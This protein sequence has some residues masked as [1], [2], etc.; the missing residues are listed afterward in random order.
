M[1]SL[2]ATTKKVA[3]SFSR[4]QA[5]SYKQ[6]EI[7]LQKKLASL[8]KKKI[9]FPE[10]VPELQP[11]VNVVERQLADIQQYHVE[12]LALRSGIRWR[13]LGELSAGYLKRTIAT[14][15]SRQMI[16]SLIHPVT[17]VLCSSRVDM[18][19]AASTFYSDLYFPDP[20]DPDAI[21]SILSTLPSSL[22]LASTDQNALT[23]PIVF[24]DILEGVS[25]CPS[26]SSPGTDGLPYEL[27][28]LIIT[29]PACRDITLAVYNDAL[30][31]GIFP[32]SWLETSVSL[33]PKKGSLSDLKNWRPISLI[34]TDA[35]VFTRILSARLISC[36]DDLITP[37]QSG[38][39]RH[40]FIADNGL[41]MK[42]VMDF[43]KSTNSKAL[44][45][46]LDQE[47]AYDRVHPDYLQQVLT[48][49]GFPPSFVQSVLGLFF[50][51]QLRLNINGFLSSPVHQRRGLRQGDP[52]SPILFNLAFEPLLRK[53]LND[54]LYNGFSI[55]H[56]PPSYISGDPLQPIKLLAYADDVLCLLKDPS[57]LNRL[58]THLD[59]YSQASNAKVNFHKTEALSLSGSRITPSSIWHG[60][61]LSHRISRWHDC[62]SANPV[63]Y[64]GYPLYTSTAQRDSYLAALLRKINTACVLHSHR[65]LSVRGRA[66]IINSLIL[67][68]LWHVLRVTSVPRA[69]LEKVKSV[70]GHFVF[71]AVSGRFGSSRSYYSTKCLTIAMDSSVTFSVPTHYLF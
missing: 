69:F 33:I 29:H 41:L 50:G 36:V 4:K 1:H 45:L 63:I 60:P 8:R 48:H 40:R 59:T 26:R 32:P 21:E 71:T 39:L 46:L 10:Q 28:R 14:R 62:H 52:L 19:D 15:A 25:R 34:N 44:G 5:S 65:S 68:K 27:L 42:L 66:T 20:V 67:S 2:K 64:L 55:P 11:L 16:P 56:A 23:S 37:Y 30:S 12:I 3:Q 49:F 43:A 61:L 18:L 38:F 7:L 51:T 57:D 54:P 31:H 47:K 24:D 22:R 6:A 9:L 58:Q 70:S 53:I 35:K 13:E 17:K